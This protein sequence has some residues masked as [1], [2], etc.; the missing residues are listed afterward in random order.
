MGIR[1]LPSLAQS[2][3]RLARINQ[4][5]QK[6]DR[7][8]ILRLET[9]YLTRTQRALTPRLVPEVA[10]TVNIRRVQL[11]TTMGILKGEPM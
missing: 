7:P 5:F 11:L 10:A 4:R 1:N 9:I 2:R 3:L 6:A 8:E